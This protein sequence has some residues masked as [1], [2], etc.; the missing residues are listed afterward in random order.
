MNKAAVERAEN[1]KRGHDKLINIMKD[2]VAYT[3]VLAFCDKQG[4]MS[5]EAIS[6]LLLNLVEKKGREG[7]GPTCATLAR[8]CAAWGCERCSVSVSVSAPALS[9]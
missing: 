9:S 1:R 2:S 4:K 5:W 6:T 3:A 7:R 8:T